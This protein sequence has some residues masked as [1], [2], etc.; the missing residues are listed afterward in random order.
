MSDIVRI[1]ESYCAS[2]DI[3]FRYGSKSH[4][5][6]LESDID[7]NQIYLLLFPPRR[8]NRFGDLGLSVKNIAYTGNFF[9][10]V[11]ANRD[12]HYFNEREQSQ[13]TSKYTVNVEPL[14][15]TFKSLGN[16]LGSCGD[17]LNINLW[18]NIDAIDVLDANK[19]GIWCT[20]EITQGE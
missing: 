18:E 20:Y 2:N 1:F 4:L 9:L 10:L 12:L 3:E 5:N 14:L 11:G 16:Y 6:L 19:D 8:K 17:D 13:L 7:P 15:S